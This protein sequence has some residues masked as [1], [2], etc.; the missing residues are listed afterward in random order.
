MPA[1]L[2]QLAA[3]IDADFRQSDRAIDQNE[4]KVMTLT[5]KYRT[6]DRESRQVGQS[7]GKLGQ[8]FSGLGQTV[9]GVGGPVGNLSNQFSG[10]I[11]TA[12]R[13]SVS[14][15]GVGVA[16]GLV[17]AATV[18]AVAGIYSL[19]TASAELTGK[20]V[21]LSQQTGFEVETLSALNNMLETSGGNLDTAANALFFFETKMGDAREKG[22][23][24]SEMFK[25][26]N[27]DTHDHEAA[28]RQ[29]LDALLSMNDAEAKATIGKK[30]FGRSVKDIL[31]AI[32][33]AGS[34]DAFLNKQLEEGTLITTKAAKAGDELSDTQV[35]LQRRFRAVT[36]TIAAE[37]SPTV[38]DALE[39]FSGWLKD[40]QKELGD[41]AREVNKLI[42]DITALANFIYSIS[43]LRLQVEIIRKFTNILDFGGDDP[44]KPVVS[45]GPGGQSYFDKFRDWMMNPT[46]TGPGDAWGRVDMSKVKPQTSDQIAATRKAN[47]DAAK[48]EAAARKKT[49][50]AV[51]KI[52]GGG[53]GGGGRGGGGRKSDPLREQQ[54]FLDASL[55]NTLESMEGEEKGIERSYEARRLKAARYFEAITSLENK[56]HEAVIETINAEIELA[57]KNNSPKEREL[58]LLNLGTE[59]QREMNRHA[60]AMHGIQSDTKNLTRERIVLV[61]T[62]VG[63]LQ[64]EREVLK[65]INQERGRFKSEIQREDLG[66]GSFILTPDERGR[67]QRSGRVVTTEETIRREQQQEMRRRAESLAADLTFLIDDSI[68]EGFRRGVG[69]GVAAFGLGI[70]QMIKHSAL[71]QLQKALADTITGAL[72]SVGMGGQQGGGGGS[73]LG[74]IFGIL[75]SGIAGGFGGFGGG[76]SEAGV[77]AANGPTGS[78]IGNF[79]DGGFMKPYQWSWV[80]ERGPELVRAG[81]Q[82]LTV[83]SNEDSA[84]GGVR[85]IHNWHIT[86]P[87]VESF[88]RGLSPTQVRR[89]VEKSM[90]SR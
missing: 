2:W 14:A 44:N 10:L 41:T 9:Q 56:R 3:K 75:I 29:A 42:K 71:Q 65:Q 57:K 21:D 16:I 37:F 31:G 59:K 87:D 89:Q 25:I 22:S 80:G 39:T 30:L 48:A 88:K 38:V 84:G 70:L 32:A 18:G 34:L 49:Q 61:D 4:R 35:L 74:K 15:G 86:T 81:A 90:R 7:S 12:G 26:L 28:L 23:E 17:T 19:T 11:G 63:R 53:G 77:A 33:E 24:M 72:S 43:P 40:N 83:R 76:A 60:Q 73:W 62:L 45:S 36:N 68:S 55:R 54:Q 13:L 50:D 58:A 85:H 51:N 66:D 52:L 1:N 67:T 79:A 5:S 20:F 6:L 46:P 69:N 47:E 64:R 78:G 82:G 8:V 27:I